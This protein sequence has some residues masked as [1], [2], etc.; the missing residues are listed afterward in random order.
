MLR[1]LRNVLLYYELKEGIKNIIKC[2]KECLKTKNKKKI[3]DKRF[4][5]VPDI[6][7][8][9]NLTKVRKI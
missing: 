6:N 5:L 8:F 2:R 7:V 4:R 1:K 3:D 9:V